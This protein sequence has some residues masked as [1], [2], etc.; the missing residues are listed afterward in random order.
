MDKEILVCTHHTHTHTHTSS[1]EGR[2]FGDFWSLVSI[3]KCLPKF[4][5]LP[6]LWD[7]KFCDIFS[8][9]AQ[10]I[11]CLYCTPTATLAQDLELCLGHQHWGIFPSCCLFVSGFGSPAFGMLGFSLYIFVTLYLRSHCQ[12]QGG[13]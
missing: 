9:R 2:T 11:P 13:A 7:P 8:N 1:W 10:V 12:I 3:A 4:L 6:L 5:S